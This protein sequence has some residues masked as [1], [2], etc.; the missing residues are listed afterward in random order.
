MNTSKLDEV[1]VEDFGPCI[2]CGFCRDGCPVS[3]YFGF[4]PQLIPITR[5]FRANQLK[6]MTNIDTT[7]LISFS[8]DLLNNL[9]FCT[10]CGYCK[11]VCPYGLDLAAFIQESRSELRLKGLKA[12]RIFEKKLLQTIRENNPYGELNKNRA[13][14]LNK[15]DFEPPKVADTVFYVGCT[16]AY[17]RQEM[18]VSAA[19]TLHRAG[20]KF[21]VLGEDEP[22]CGSALIRT[23]FPEQTEEQAKKIISA[24][25]NVKEIVVACAGCYRT[26]I[27]DYP[28]LGINL[29][30]KVTHTTEYIL[31]LIRANKLLLGEVNK[32]ITYHDPCHLAR[33]CGIYDAPREI[34]KSIPGIELLEMHPTRHISWCCG[35]GGGVKMAF[36]GPA[37]DIASNKIE[38]ALEIGVEAIVTAC[39]F[40]ST[41]LKDAAKGKGL[42]IYGIEEV[43]VQSI[44]SK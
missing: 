14:W 19:E 33:H 16:M 9:Y 42:D 13:K 4:E 26:F 25:K 44:T 3:Q 31:N 1:Y 38:L 30:F 5:L 34:L 22:C 17:R 36:P 35:A 29:P 43:V 20:V 10:S 24:L 8:D 39:P 15:L 2:T 23:G 6:K 27:V 18:A 28:E 32:N 37:V 41:N 7:N 40:C 12:R 11:E 21:A